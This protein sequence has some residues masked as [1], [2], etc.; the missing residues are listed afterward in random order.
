[1]RSAK[2]ASG[3]RTDAL[4]IHRGGPAAALPAEPDA[5]EGDELPRV[6][7]A[8]QGRDELYRVGVKR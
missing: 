1:M 3:G 5:Q 8:R 7:F 6:D 4:W 2:R